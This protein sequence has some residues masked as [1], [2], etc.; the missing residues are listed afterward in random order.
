VIFVAAIFHTKPSLF[1]LRTNAALRPA[2]TPLEGPNGISSFLHT[3]PDFPLSS[4]PH[5]KREFTTGIP[6]PQIYRQD[7]AG[8]FLGPLE[9]RQSFRGWLVNSMTPSHKNPHQILQHQFLFLHNNLPI[10]KSRMLLS[11]V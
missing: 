7:Y 11:V 9:G 2:Q 6:C 4:V 8:C 1:L 3:M 5:V 10:K